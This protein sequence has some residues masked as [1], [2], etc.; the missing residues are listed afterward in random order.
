MPVYSYRISP[1]NVIA[2]ID[3]VDGDDAQPIAYEGLDADD[4]KAQLQK[5]YGAFGHRFNPDGD[6]PIDLHHALVSTFGADA[7]ADLGEPLEYAPNIPDG[8]LA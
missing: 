4:I 1:Y 8:V 2:T 5:A 3:A 7:I 6:T